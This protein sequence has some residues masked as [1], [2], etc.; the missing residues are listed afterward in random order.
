MKISLAFFIVVL[1]P[2]WQVGDGSDDDDCDDD[3]DFIP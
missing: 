2:V 1:F 3:D